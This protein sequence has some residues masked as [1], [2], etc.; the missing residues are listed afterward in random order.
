M[1]RK[2]QSRGKCVF[3]GREMTRGGLAK[4]LESC[5]ARQEAVSHADQNPGNEQTIYH[6]QVQDAWAGDFWLHLEMRD[7]ATLKTLDS[8]LRTIWLECC[9][10]L[11]QFSFDSYGDEQVGMSRK[12]GSVFRP[13]MELLHIY[14]FG[15]SSETKI[16]V[17]SARQGKP[18]TKHS[19]YLM[20]RNEPPE[21]KCCKCGEPAAWL[22]MECEDEET[23]AALLLCGKHVKAHK[24]HAILPFVNS[25]R[26]GMCG[27]EGPAE[28]PY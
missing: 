25:P 4:H 10:H 21:V 27:Y 9:G 6:L 22:C 8:Y 20:A 12:A 14:D 15:T 3:C 16:K 28:P 13:G 1:A 7:S 23:G 5:A 26:T 19:I 18:L 11:S 2:K 24:E 17:V